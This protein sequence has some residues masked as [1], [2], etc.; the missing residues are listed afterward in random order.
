MDIKVEQLSAALEMN[1]G[2]LIKKINS[3]FDDIHVENKDSVLTREEAKRIIDVLT[4]PEISEEQSAPAEPEEYVHPADVVETPYDPNARDEVVPSQQDNKASVSPET[5]IN[6]NSSIVNDNTL[7][8][9]N[10]P[11][12]QPTNQTYTHPYDVV[13]EPYVSNNAGGTSDDDIYFR[14]QKPEDLPFIPYSPDGQKPLNESPVLYGIPYEEQARQ[15]LLRQQIAEQARQ[16]T[17][18]VERVQNAARARQEQIDNNQG[19]GSS[20]IDFS[21]NRDHTNTTERMVDNN[22]PNAQQNTPAGTV[23]VNYPNQNDLFDSQTSNLNRYLRRESNLQNDQVPNTYHRSDV[24]SKVITQSYTQ[25]QRINDLML[26]EREKGTNIPYAPQFTSNVNYSVQN[27]RDRVAKSMG[28]FVAAPAQQLVGTLKQQAHSDETLRKVRDVKDIAVGVGAIGGFIAMGGVTTPMKSWGQ[29]FA[30]TGNKIANAGRYVMGKETVSRAKQAY[31]LKQVQNKINQDFGGASIKALK[32]ER[33][34]LLGLQK[35]GQILTSAQAARLASL[36]GKIQGIKTLSNQKESLL[37][38]KNQ[39][40]KIGTMMNAFLREMSQDANDDSLGLLVKVNNMAGNKRIHAVLKYAGKSGRYVFKTAFKATKSGALYVARKTGLDK[41]IVEANK[42][43]LHTKPVLKFNDIK[44]RTKKAINGGL[45]NKAKAKLKTKVPTKIQTAAKRTVGVGKKVGTSFK[46]VGKGAKKAGKVIAAPAKFIKKAA[47]KISAALTAV[48]GFLL[49][50]VGIAALVIALFIVIIQCIAIPLTQILSFDINL[51]PNLIPFIQMVNKSEKDFRAEIE[52]AVKDGKVDGK[53]YDRIIYDYSN[54]AVTNN[55]REIISMTAVFF[56]ND[57]EHA[58]NSSVEKYIDDLYRNSHAVF[59]YPSEPYSCANGCST[60]NY[61]CTEK[62][63]ATYNESACIDI[64]YCDGCKTKIV[65]CEGCVE[66]TTYCSGCT[67]KREQCAGANCEKILG[68]IPYC[69]GHDVPHCDGHIVK[70]CTTHEELYCPGH[71]EYKCQGKHT[72]KYCPGT[73]Q[74]MTIN[75]VVDSW[76]DIFARDSYSRGNNGV[77]FPYVKYTTWYGTDDT[78]RKDNWQGW[79]QGNR[80]WAKTLYEQDWKELYIGGNLVPAGNQ[81]VPMTEEEIDAFMQEMSRNTTNVRQLSYSR[82]MLLKTLL[83][84]VGKVPYYENGRYTF[85][86]ELGG[87][88]PMPDSYGNDKIGLDTIGLLQY[89]Y[90]NS[91]SDTK[92]VMHK[93]D[94]AKTYSDVWYKT[95][96]IEKSEMEPGDIGFMNSCEVGPDGKIIPVNYIGIF[97]GKCDNGSGVWI[98]I[99]NEYGSVTTISTEAFNYC[100]RVD[101]LE[102]NG[103]GETWEEVK[104]YLDAFFGG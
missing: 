73:H 16:N 59:Y 12:N 81:I 19:F 101:G 67:T 96:A 7:N 20:G 10:A 99:D 71:V 62:G 29:N 26:Q 38:L 8:T 72:E 43:L 15:E 36:E 61:K 23:V 91:L 89:A 48:K 28:Q 90:L 24:E 104:A 39:K 77:V 83:R 103:Y 78:E 92:E 13:E 68:F 69:P 51:K 44:L 58:K 35:K 50:I 22:I 42:K 34:E 85:G 63:H 33:K 9:S 18:V 60:R 52:S 6:N 80:D 53:T 94:D 54:G 5:P 1:T 11:Q 4:K 47:S 3:M 64:Q 100:R 57:L 98:V 40:A 49:K 84:S 56:D 86:K 14:T 76:D 79:T 88:A 82:F 25:R 41:V 93:F 32:A 97:A 102:I 2:L 45:Y 75:I 21:S 17:D 70:S 46:N 30:M 87:K 55:M 66:E 27:A 74:D 95:Y 31:T 37:S 65:T